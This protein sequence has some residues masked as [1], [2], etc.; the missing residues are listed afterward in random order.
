MEC[1]YRLL[2]RFGGNKGNPT[3]LNLYKDGEAILKWVRENTKFSK[4]QIIIYERSL[5]SGVAVELGIQIYFL[6]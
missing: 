3:E 4:E 6:V 2:E 1:Y 5:G